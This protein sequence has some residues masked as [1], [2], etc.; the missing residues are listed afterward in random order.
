MPAPNIV[1]PSQILGRSDP[2]ARKSIF[3]YSS[4][5]A[6]SPAESSGSSLG[7]YT[8]PSVSPAECSPKM[9][10]QSVPSPS[11]P[12]PVVPNPARHPRRPG[13]SLVRRAIISPARQAPRPNS[14]FDNEEGAGC[15]FWV[16][17]R[18]PV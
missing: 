11:E 13:P 3:A 6:A 10:G 5:S 9:S 18:E 12:S 8:L 2:Q 16:D 7:C 1:T 4:S 15:S 17:G 14:D